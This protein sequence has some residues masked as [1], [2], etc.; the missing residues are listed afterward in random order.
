[1]SDKTSINTVRSPDKKEFFLSIRSKMLIYFG[2]MFILILI[3]YV[4][5]EIFGIPFTTFKGEYNQHQSEVF[6][7]LNLFADLKK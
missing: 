4:L 3:I 5:S 2:S 6:R 1:M 7:N